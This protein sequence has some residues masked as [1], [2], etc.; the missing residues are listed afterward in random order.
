MVDTCHTYTIKKEDDNNFGLYRDGTRLAPRT[1]YE[2]PFHWLVEIVLQVT[3]LGDSDLKLEGLD[4][5]DE[6]DIRTLFVAYKE[7]DMKIRRL[8][9]KD[10]SI[11]PA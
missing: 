7:R 5:Q 8:S 9:S 4:T 3:N 6:S 1:T 2:T 10:K 11:R